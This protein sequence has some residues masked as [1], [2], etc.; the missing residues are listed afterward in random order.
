MFDTFDSKTSLRQRGQWTAVLFPKRN[1]PNP[2]FH[3]SIA[4]SVVVGTGICVAFY[5]AIFAGPLD[6]AMLRR[7]CLCHP[8]AIATA[9]LFFV[10]IVA[11]SSKWFNASLQQRKVRQ[12]G[13]ALEEISASQAE[14]PET[15]SGEKKAVWFDTLWRTQSTTVGDSW[16]GQRVTAV[17]QRQ[18]KRKNTKHLDQDIAELA[19]RDAD[20]QHDS[21]GLIR[22]VTWAMPM[23]GFLGTVLGISDTLGQMDAKALS[24][25]SQDAMN[26]LTA[27]LYVAFDTT[28][29]GLVLTMVAMFVQFA[30]NRT[31]LALLSA[32]DGKVSETL[33]LCLTEQEKQNDTRNVESALHHVTQELLKSVQQIVQTQSELWEQTISAAHCHWQNLT[34]TSAE[35]IQSSMAAAIEA[36]LG[37]HD[38][39]LNHHT[40][41]LARVQTEGAVL[42]DSRWQQWQT[43]LSEQTRAVY[44][45]QREMSAQTALLNML[46]EKHDAIRDMEK[47][48]QATL[49]RLTDIDRFHNAAVCLTEAVAVLGTQMERYGYLGRQPVRRRSAEPVA[50]VSASETAESEVPTILPLTRQAG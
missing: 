17:L 28:A 3:V 35:T 38:S 20:Q 1:S 14:T 6:Y 26:S 2:S 13:L 34:S 16:L 39:S 4:P 24:S 9:G 41:Q 32:I 15:D 7:Y 31:E 29:I 50:E 49:E 11:L 5:G 48:L 43:T 23:L 47:P 22:I 8:V 33:Q 30:V 44:H 27:G 18:L 25:G 37:K 21:Y 42:I 10:A 36:A 19:E 12:G 40:E 45:Q 46:I